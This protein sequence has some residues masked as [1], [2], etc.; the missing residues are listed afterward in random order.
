MPGPLGLH[1]RVRGHEEGNGSRKD[2]ACVRPAEAFTHRCQVRRSRYSS[3]VAFVIAPA[4][5]ATR[6]QHGQGAEGR[7]QPAAL[8]EVGAGSGARPCPRFT[9]RFSPGTGGRC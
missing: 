8:A 5:S 6:K 4:H 1:P 3:P 7:G 2:A 9:P